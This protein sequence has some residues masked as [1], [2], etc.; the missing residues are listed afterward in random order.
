DRATTS[1]APPTPPVT[2]GADS[3]ATSVTAPQPV[4]VDLAG[5]GIAEQIDTTK[6]TSAVPTRPPGPRGPERLT[7]QAGGAAARRRMLLVA[8]AVVA[9]LV[10]VAAGVFAFRGGNTIGG[11]G[12]AGTNATSV[13]NTAA[14]CGALDVDFT[15]G[16]N[17]TLV[18]HNGN[19]GSFDYQAGGLRLSEQPKTDVRSRR[20]GRNIATWLG[21]T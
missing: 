1:A 9:A 5:T 13:T 21:D 17:A 4:A 12:L 14:N 8:G 15:K 10:T 3:A 7:E 16:A 20:G 18:T 19:A 11:T 6:A 2:S